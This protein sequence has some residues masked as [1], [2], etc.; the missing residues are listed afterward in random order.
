MIEHVEQLLADDR[1]NRLAQTELPELRSLRANLQ[2]VESDMSLVRR[3]TQGRLDIVGHEVSS[4]SS[5]AA[6]DLDMSDLLFDLPDILAD[7]PGG[8]SR[9]RV[10]L[11]E[12]GE[13]AHGLTSRLDE[14]VSPSSLGALSELADED[15][16]GVLEALQGFEAEL[17]QTRKELHQRIDAIQQEIGRR[18][19]EGEATT[20]DAFNA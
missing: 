9:G 15:L 10:S 5:G 8:A 20:A 19:K 18:Y 7:A 16:G 1:N 11:N 17:S 14:L 4:R 6:S 12:P 3:L 13:T 2:A